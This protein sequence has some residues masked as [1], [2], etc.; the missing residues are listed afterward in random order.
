MEWRI[1]GKGFSFGG[2]DGGVASSDVS[3]REGSLEE[4]LG[5]ET[6]EEER[7]RVAATTTQARC[8]RILYPFAA[9]IQNRGPRFSHKK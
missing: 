5:L 8:L 7:R 1:E 9:F 4:D 2:L 3:S 6:D